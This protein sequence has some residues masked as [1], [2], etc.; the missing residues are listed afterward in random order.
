M[1]KFF[2]TLAMLLSIFGLSNLASPTYAGGSTGGGTGGTTCDSLLG[3]VSWNCN[4]PLD[5]FFD[6]EDAIKAN[7][8]LIVANVATDL[9]V[10]ASY[11]VLGYVIYGGYFYILANGD[12]TKVA[13]GKKIL[14]QAFVGLAIVMSASI[15]LNAIRIGLGSV[16]LTTDCITINEA[17]TGQSISGGTCVDPNT[18]VTQLISWVIGMGGVVAVIFVVFGGISLIT[19]SGDP[20]KAE[21]AKKT[22]TYALIGMAIVGL[23]EIITAFVSNLIRNAKNNATAFTPTSSLIANT[24]TTHLDTTNSLIKEKYEIKTR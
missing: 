7:I 3:F 6:S 14:G 5:S 22:I 24:D 19:S 4:V 20:T 15:I 16:N 18:M 1:K 9:S 10:A 12:S 8:W 11:L 13:T 21:K 23:A 17:N 2:I